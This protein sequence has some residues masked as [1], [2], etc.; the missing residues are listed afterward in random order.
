MRAK[1]FR[2]FVKNRIFVRV[3]TFQN[4]RLKITF[5]I[6]TFKRTAL[7]FCYAKKYQKVSAILNSSV[8]RRTQTVISPF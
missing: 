3:I 5:F 7:T 6:S 1:I 8:S 4:T 2:F